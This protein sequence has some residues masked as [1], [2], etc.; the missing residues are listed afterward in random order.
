MSVPVTYVNGLLSFLLDG[1]MYQINS[2]HPNYS[3]ILKAFVKLNTEQIL[4]DLLV[5]KSVKTTST[6]TIKSGKLLVDNNKVTFNG[7]EL[8]EVLTKGVLDFI[9]LEIPLT[10]IENFL[11]RLEDNP[12][13][14]TFR[15]VII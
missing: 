1:K 5:E 13:F 3:H 6:K 2:E 11:L 7:E 9:K 15:A 4:R 14:T 10:Y 8:P 12:R